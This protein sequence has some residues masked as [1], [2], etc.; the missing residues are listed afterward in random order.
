[1]FPNV[2]DITNYRAALPK[3]ATSGQP[4]EAQLAGIAAAGYEVVVNLALH[5]DP[6]Y[7]LPDEPGTVRALGMD[8]VHIPVR[9]DAPTGQDLQGFSAAL[10]KHQ[11]RRVWIRCAANI[12]VTAFLGLHR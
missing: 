5:D 3:M 1:M 11:G 2:A 4:A 7:S 9:F 12:R 10:V 6:C 8:Y